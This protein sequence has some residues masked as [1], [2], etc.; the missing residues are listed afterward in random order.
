MVAR[1]KSS[2]TPDGVVVIATNRRASFE[3]ELGEKFE[4]GL[5]L[6]GSEVKSLRNRSANIV[7]AWAVVRNGE[8]F[9]EGMTISVLAHAAFGH[10]DDRP[11]KLLLHSREI[12][13]LR[14]AIERKGLTAVVTRL[15][16]RDG[17]AK[18][19]IALAKGRNKGDKREAIKTKDADREA[20]AAID[21]VRRRG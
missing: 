5:V 12:E 21:A 3:Y 14:D 7:D 6:I 4:A 10:K 16:F 15:Y 13:V 19:E 9:V 18:V 17:R 8:M 20:Q 1:A 11:R 2:K